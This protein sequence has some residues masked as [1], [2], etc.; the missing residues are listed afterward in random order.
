MKEEEI[1]SLACD[2]HETTEYKILA[3]S[4][5]TDERILLVIANILNDIR[6]ILETKDVN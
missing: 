2:K 6:L 3:L 1:K 5:F 4:S